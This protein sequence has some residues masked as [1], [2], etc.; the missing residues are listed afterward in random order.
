MK[1]NENDE[2]VDSQKLSKRDKQ[3]L[4]EGACVNCA[5]FLFLFAFM[6]AIFTA[7]VM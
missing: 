1:D 3:E 2:V 7:L 5:V 6:F 4:Q